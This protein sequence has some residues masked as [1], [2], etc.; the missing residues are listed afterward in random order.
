[1]S[2][3]QWYALD[4]RWLTQVE[5]AHESGIA[6]LAMVVAVCSLIAAVLVRRRDP[7]MPANTSSR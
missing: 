5:L 7:T 3:G 1:V 6:G 4:A 2:F